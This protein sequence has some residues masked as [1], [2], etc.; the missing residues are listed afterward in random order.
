M[1][2][3]TNQDAKVIKEKVDKIEEKTNITEKEVVTRTKENKNQK[4]D[5]NIKID[6]QTISIDLQERLQKVVRSELESYERE[7][8][9]NVGLI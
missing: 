6:V 1:P 4:I 7:Q 3:S 2:T 8:L 9:V 5:L